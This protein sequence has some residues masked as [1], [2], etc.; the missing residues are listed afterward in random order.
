M[1]SDEQGAVSSI[2]ER[3]LHI[4]LSYEQWKNPRK[5]FFSEFMI[6]FMFEH[7]QQIKNITVQ[8]MHQP[9]IQFHKTKDDKCKSIQISL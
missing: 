8:N 7:V 2:G 1:T 6:V 5:D 9:I 3:R 4:Y